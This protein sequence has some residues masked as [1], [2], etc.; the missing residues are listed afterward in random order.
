MGVVQGRGAASAQPDSAVAVEARLALPADGFSFHASGPVF[1]FR[2]VMFL[3]DFEAASR[4]LR[5]RWDAAGLRGAVKGYVPS[6]AGYGWLGFTMARR[7]GLEFRSMAP[8]LEAGGA[9][10]FRGMFVGGRVRQ[11]SVWVPQM[12]LL[13]TE[14]HSPP[15]FRS[16][17]DIIPTVPYWEPREPELS[18]L[19]S[20][21]ATAHWTHTRWEVDAAGGLAVGTRNAPIPLARVQATRWLGPGLGVVLGATAGRPGWLF[22]ELKDR[23]GVQ[24]GV[25]L[26]PARDVPAVTPLRGPRTDTSPRQWSVVKLRDRLLSFRVRGVEL[27]RVA[28]RGDFTSWETVPLQRA[29]SGWWEITLPLSSG[30]HQWEVSV[31][32]AE[33]RPP[34]GVPTTAGIYG[35]EVGML[36]VQ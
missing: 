18:V 21:E 22:D 26:E 6:R 3:A 15:G 11:Q 10:R 19:T 5:D 27:E 28:L 32:G 14:W 12:P 23:S 34:P 7:A 20:L 30:V 33:W 4:R 31:N 25:R 1:A 29:G 36:V 2:S 16:P 8:L 24:L 13:V 17:P 35:G 9:T